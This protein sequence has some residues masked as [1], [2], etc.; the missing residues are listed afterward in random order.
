MGINAICAIKGV[1]L[2]K[3]LMDS[4][5]S[6]LVRVSGRRWGVGK[7]EVFWSL[8]AHFGLMES[9]PSKLEPR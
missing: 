4:G 2:C 7:G 9:T 6:C 3:G 8:D 5:A 1:A